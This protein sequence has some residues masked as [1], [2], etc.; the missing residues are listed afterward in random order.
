MRIL[1]SS[2]RGTGHLQPL[3][4]YA[5]ALLKHGHEVLFAGPAAIGGP[6]REAGFSHAPFGHPGDEVLAPI[7]A[8]L[9]GIT[10]DEMNRIAAREIFAGVN[11]SAAFPELLATIKRFRP[12][13]V[14]RESAEF[15]ASVAAE[16]AGVPH[17]CV[18]VHCGFVE[19]KLYAHAIEPIDALRRHAG[20]AADAG[21]ALR[22]E[23]V[24]TAFPPS[25]DGT[26]AERQ[27][28]APL[29]IRMADET[30]SSATPYWAPA[31]D[32]TLLIYITF[33]TIVGGMADA[34]S[35]YRTSLEA[36]AS[37]PVRALLTTGPG[38]EHDM[39]G[40]I[41]ANVRVEAWVPQ[42]DVLP[43]V[44]ALVCHGGSGT[45][46]GALAA[47]IPLVVVPL[48]AD[49]PENARRIA[50]AGAGIALPKPDAAALRGAIERVLADAELRRGAQK[51]AAEFAAMPTIERA[52]DALVAL[53]AR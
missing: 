24:F 30:P 11:A 6:V 36:V 3:M 50:A 47:G 39:L 53:G 25:L 31:D 20:L 14:V 19:E 52:I 10:E 38:I 44:A 35:I 16:A 42:R 23:P 21:A 18:Q 46:T 34:R 41:P 13:V 15:A 5:R 37:L 8:R 32:G 33:G 22:A 9:R 49:Q 7:W 1:F 27:L 26:G 43:H 45:V 40:P 29:R 12:D 28:H 51:I 17:A 48:G 2:T 4:P